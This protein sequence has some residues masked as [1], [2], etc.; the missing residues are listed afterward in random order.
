MKWYSLQKSELIYSENI[1]KDWLHGGLYYKAFYGCNLRIFVISWSVCPWQAFPAQSDILWVRPEPT[2]VKNLSGAPLQ[3]RLLASP[4]NIRL[5]WKGKHFSL[6]RKS[7]N[8][9]RK[10]FIVQVPDLSTDSKS[11]DIK[12]VY[13]LLNLNKF[14]SKNVSQDQVL[15]LYSQR[16]IFA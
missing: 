1:L 2:R 8:Y 14:I 5:G 15:G 3:G 10:S 13:R 7:V 16:F 4:T 6:L 12:L 11:R 9:G